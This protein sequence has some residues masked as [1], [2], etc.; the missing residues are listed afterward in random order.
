MKKTSRKLWMSLV[1]IALSLPGYCE[2]IVP[3]PD[4]PPGEA[5][6]DTLTKYVKVLGEYLGYDLEKATTPMEAMLDYTF[7]IAKTGQQVLNVFFAAIP[8][9]A[10]FLE[11]SSNS[12]YQNFN[13]QANVL[14]TDYHTP[15]GQA[16]SV[17]KLLDNPAY[18]DDPVSQAVLNLVS[19]PNDLLCP[20]SGDSSD[21][22]LNQT[23]VMN[24]VIKDIVDKDGV[25]PGETMYFS[26]KN[27]E[28]F[29]SQLNVNTLISPLIYA[30]TSEAEQSA[31]NL[32]AKS[33]EQQAFEFV[34]YATAAVLPID[35]MSQADYQALRNQAKT[36][37]DGL[38]Q[39]GIDSIN[40]AKKE[41]ASYLIGLRVYAAQSSVA[42]S[43]LYGILAKRMPQAGST[44]ANGNATPT[45]QAFN[46]FQSAT[47][48]LYN[49]D[50]KAT[51][52]GQWVDQINAG[53]PATIQKEIA[54]LLS[55]M[56]YQLYL[57]RQQEERILLTNSLALIQLMANNKPNIA[58]LNGG[59]SASAPDS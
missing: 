21:D 40:S 24:T 8:V 16:V 54:I 49:P 41:L 52:N 9:N 58:P 10:T 5:N 37:P 7:S 19:T 45:S 39:A 18:Q 22:C 27:S 47:W 38:D 6:D 46:E 57:N 15:N 30:T 43:N 53:S 13:T 44:D 36:S 48:R 31:N 56:N 42:I 20:S 25:P 26:K 12:S 35:T 32:P 3:N 59:N 1:L 4:A 23:D 14:F 50:P 28:T 2:D 11:F 33:Q 29:L 34:R 55:E 17:A 51:A